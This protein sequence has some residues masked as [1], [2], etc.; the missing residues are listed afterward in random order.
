MGR[1]AP[2][3]SPG[4]SAK[5]KI[6]RNVFMQLPTEAGEEPG[7]TYQYEAA[8]KLYNRRN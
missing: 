8:E 6:P 7:N 5:T 4:R 2:Q 1:V 3:S